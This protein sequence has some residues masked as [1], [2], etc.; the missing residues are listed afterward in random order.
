MIASVPSLPG[1][2][3]QRPN[4]PSLLGAVVLTAMAG[5]LG[6]GIRGQYGHESGA[7]IAGLLVGFTLVLL[8]L[9]RATSLQ[10]ARS[11]ALIALGIS[12]GGSMTY[13]QTVGLTH[14]AA[15]VGNWSALRWG[16]LGLFIKGGI[17]IAFAG[18][19]LG[20]GLGGKRYRPWEMTGLL[21]GMVVLLL[22]GMWTVNGPFDPQ[23]KLLP[24]VYFSDHWH[25][26]PGAQLK[27]RPECWGG[28]LLALVGLTAYVHWVRRD[29]LARNMALV[30]FLAGGLGFSLGQCVQAFHAWNPG[31]FRSGLLG[32]LDPHI[33][34]WNM[35]EI[36]FGMIFGG[37]LALG[38]WLNR[39]GI[40]HDGAP[41]K[42]VISPPWEFALFA[43]HLV[44]VVGAEFWDVFVLAV[45][46]EIGFLMALAPLIGILG[47]RYWPYLFALPIVAAPIAGK[48]LR[49]LSY[50]NEEISQPLGW[51]L[52]IVVPLA[53]TLAAAI[54]LARNGKE[55][56]TSRRFARVGLLLTTW[57]YFGLNFAFFRLPWPWEAWTGRTPSAIIFT[58]C[59]LALTAAAL[60]APGNRGGEAT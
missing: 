39:R 28:L 1:N 49:E 56:Q 14:D 23:N 13:G 10:A 9:P 44:V 16:L 55:G 19:F 2:S 57:L 20:M 51:I 25:W 37:G 24:R 26:E 58:V 50:K 48:T 29:R 42:V 4:A 27:P 21:L 3:A 15:L 22:V 60:I 7:M 45:F 18:L 12:F 46:L 59:A 32:K 6:W 36:S 17:W 5:G 40:A 34:W 53:L 43:V 41:D 47:G 11:V 30:G 33:N 38:L 52:F 35:M 54:W 8:F 31:L